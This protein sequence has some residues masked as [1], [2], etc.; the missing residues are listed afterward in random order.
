MTDKKLCAAG[1]VTPKRDCTADYRHM[2]PDGV[3][4]D[5]VLNPEYWR[6]V[7]KELGWSITKNKKSY[8]GVEC[9]AVDGSWE[10]YL[11]VMDVDTGY[12]KVR[13]LWKYEDVSVVT[14][15]TGLPKGHKLE[16][17][18]DGW[19]VLGPNNDIVARD[20]AT[21]ADAIRDAKEKIKKIA[22]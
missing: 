20:H 10:C 9:I 5:D 18:D 8:N 12:A 13:L 16:H 14:G 2:V 19:R 22:A 7:T 6:N 1:G 11:R 21:K 3:T 15:A 17:V 4:L